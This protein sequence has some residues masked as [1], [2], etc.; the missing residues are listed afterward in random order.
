MI[1]YSLADPGA[2]INERNDCFVRA[3]ATASDIPYYQA[4]DL[5]KWLGRKERHSTQI[6]ISEQVCKTGNH[7]LELCKIA[8]ARPVKGYITHAQFIKQHPKGTFLVMT[9]R[10]IWAIKDGVSFDSWMPG[11]KK[12]IIYIGVVNSPC[13]S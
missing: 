7:A 11:A 6:N 9:K 5:L 12:R 1:K 13:N 2:I 3:L 10:H 8:P 4:H